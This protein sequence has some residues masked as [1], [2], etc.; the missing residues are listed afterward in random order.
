MTCDL[1]ILIPR[2]LTQTED[3]R[4]SIDEAGR[5]TCDLAIL[6]PRTLTQTE[7]LTASIEEVDG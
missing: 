6:I 4:A 2:T 7:D 5:V 3:L 1:A